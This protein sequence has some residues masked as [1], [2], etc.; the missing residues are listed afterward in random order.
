M[1][2]DFILGLNLK[3]CNAPFKKSDERLFNEN[4]DSLAP[5]RGKIL[6]IFHREIWKESGNMAGK[7]AK[8]FAQKRILSK[9]L[10]NLLCQAFYQGAKIAFFKI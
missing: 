10:L 4:G 9:H 7:N 3:S 5:I 2:C 8:C 1:S 6:P